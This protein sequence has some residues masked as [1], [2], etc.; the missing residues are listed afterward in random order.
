MPTIWIYMIE[1]DHFLCTQN[2]PKM[3]AAIWGRFSKLTC[4]T[5]KILDDGQSSLILEMW[6]QGVLSGQYW[7]GESLWFANLCYS[8]KYA[9]GF[10]NRNKGQNSRDRSVELIFILFSETIP[11]WEEL[12]AT[13]LVHFPYIRFLQDRHE[14][15]RSWHSHRVW[16]TKMNLVYR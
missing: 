7:L 3:S 16:F 10:R 12:P 2:I 15:G 14:K 11:S 8:D 9:A 5:R 6:L 1:A 13:F 4:W